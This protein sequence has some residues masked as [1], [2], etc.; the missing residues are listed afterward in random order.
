M[1]DRDAKRPE[2]FRLA[3][4]QYVAVASEADGWVPSECLGVRL[5]VSTDTPPRLA[6]EDR[7]DPSLRVEI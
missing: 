7:K 6:I 1:I 2:V 5:R 3:G 4:A